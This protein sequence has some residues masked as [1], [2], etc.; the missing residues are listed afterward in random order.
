ML[1]VGFFIFFE[2]LLLIQFLAGGGPRWGF[3]ATMLAL[4]VPLFGGVNPLILYHRFEPRLGF[5][6]LL[7]HL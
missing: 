7:L 3:L 2:A 1:N 4:Y 5:E 6:V